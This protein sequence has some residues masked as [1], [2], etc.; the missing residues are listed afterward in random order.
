MQGGTQHEDSSFWGN[1]FCENKYSDRVRLQ[2]NITVLKVG[3]D[4]AKLKTKA[5]FSDNT[6]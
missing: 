5:V 2:K 6:A 1:I 4:F 3:K